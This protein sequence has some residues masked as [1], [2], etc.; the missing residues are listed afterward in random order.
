MDTAAVGLPQEK[1]PA[2]KAKA[3]NRSPK[4]KMLKES[5]ARQADLQ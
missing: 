4:E 3:P 2:P 1:K 5:F